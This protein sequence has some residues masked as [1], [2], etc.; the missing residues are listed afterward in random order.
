MTLSRNRPMMRRLRLLVAHRRAGVADKALALILAFIAGGAN[1]GG[2]LALGQFTSHMTGYLSLMAD[3]IALANLRPVLQSVLAIALFLAGAALSAVLVNW[4]RHHRPRA[5]YALPVALQGVL[6]LGFAGLGLLGRAH[7]VANPAALGLLCLIMGVQNATITKLSGARI[8]TT[9]VT[10]IVTDLGI[11][12]GRAAYRHGSGRALPGH[13]P[14]KA[15]MLAQLVAAFL[16]GG[17]AGA[18]GY[19]AFGFLFALP[20]ALVLLAIALPALR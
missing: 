5:Q 16:L 3:N 10:G 1:A 12:I 8:R 15:V 11:E 4:A 19:G 14:R 20:M 2:F 9:H 17:I 6:L 7:P 13:D 18:L